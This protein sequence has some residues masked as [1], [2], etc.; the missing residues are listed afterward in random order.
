M[1]SRIHYSNI[2]I[3]IFLFALVFLVYGRT[4]SVGFLS[5]DWHALAIAKDTAPWFF[6][7][8]NIEGGRS[9]SSYGPFWNLFINAEYSVFGLSPLPYH[10]TSLVLFAATAFV[11]FLFVERQTGSRRLGLFTGVIWLL[12]PSHVEPVAWISG[13]P[14]LLA[15]LFFML[16]L[17]WFFFF[18]QTGRKRWYMLAIGAFIC[19]LL[20]KEIGITAL[21]GFVAIDLF[22]SRE[23]RAQKRIM[24]TIAHA[25]VP[26]LIVIGYLAMRR[27][28]TGIVAGYYGAEAIA[29]D[30]YLYIR[31]A[32]EMT[33]NMFLSFPTRAQ[34]LAVASRH[35]PLALFAAGLA[36]IAARRKRESAFAFLMYGIALLPYL[37]LRYNQFGDEGERYAHLPSLFAA[38]ILAIS[39]QGI[40]SRFRATRVPVF[41]ICLI[42]FIAASGVIQKKITVWQTAGGIV[43]GELAALPK[44]GI[45]PSRPI[46][47]VGLPDHLLGAQMFRNGLKEAM[48]FAGYDVLSFER[49]PYFLTLPPERLLSE[50]IFLQKTEEEIVLGAENRERVFTG[51][52]AYAT[53]L[54]TSTLI[55]YTKADERGNE[56]RLKLRATDIQL[57]YF[58]E[59]NFRLEKM[60]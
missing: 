57:L 47:A 12:F 42:L 49:I 13:Q 50:K 37:P 53:S 46:F 29:D 59:G 27:Y 23:K 2:F 38:A 36:F 55:G 11:L 32:L 22:Y 34:A 9:G 28:A 1:P 33:V 25:A 15:T 18:V 52:S 6:F 48:R 20:T 43:A 8:A 21:A 40:F 24:R 10:L 7:G 5:D 4:V 56:I 14:H 30:P 58:S 3:F 17:L 44:L 31:M 26:L 19:S 54:A 39:M 51:L 41:A 35:L 60:E 16:S 45:D